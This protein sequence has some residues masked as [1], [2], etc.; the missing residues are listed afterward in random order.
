VIPTALLLY[1]HRHL[2]LR[3]PAPPRAE[4]AHVADDRRLASSSARDRVG[5]EAHRWIRRS[6]VVD[7]LGSAE[8]LT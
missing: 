2:A 5:D 6:T 1:R 7:P 8:S 3:D 4:T